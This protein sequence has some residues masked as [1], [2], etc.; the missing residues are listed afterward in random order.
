[1]YTTNDIIALDHRR[2]TNLVDIEILQPGDEGVVDFADHIFY[3]RQ[4]PNFEIFDR[5]PSEITALKSAY[6]DMLT[7]TF[8]CQTSSAID[9]EENDLSIYPNPVE[10]QLQIDFGENQSGAL[11]IY[12]LQGRKVISQDLAATA[13][14]LVDLHKLHSGLYVVRFISDEEKVWRA[15]F[16][17]R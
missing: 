2:L 12:D 1:M 13:T 9:L 7:G 5:W 10:D 3:D 14:H 8:N 15:R 17:K 11:S 6:T 4:S 16:V